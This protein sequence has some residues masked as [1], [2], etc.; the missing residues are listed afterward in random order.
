MFGETRVEQVLA[1][2]EACHKANPANHVRL[3]GY[4]KRKQTQGAAMVI[5][6][7]KAV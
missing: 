3:V 6:R 5:F 1:E 2:A 4:D 7:G